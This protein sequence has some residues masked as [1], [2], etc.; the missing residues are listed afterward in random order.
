MVCPS[1]KLTDW[2]SGV[3]SVP[4]VAVAGVPVESVTDTAPALPPTRST[5]NGIGPWPS[6][7]RKAPVVNCSA[8]G[9]ATAAV[10]TVIDQPPPMEPTSPLVSSTAYSCQTPLGLLPLNTERAVADDGAGAGAGKVSP[11]RRCCCV[12]R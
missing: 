12:G 5:V 11:S 4:G 7:P 3:K 9:C 2:L 8:P 1:A 10:V 6:A